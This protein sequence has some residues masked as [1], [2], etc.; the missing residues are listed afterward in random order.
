MKPWSSLISLDEIIA[1]HAKAM[2]DF[3]QPV[4]HAGAGVQN[5]VEGRLG[6]AWTSDSY[7]SDED[8]K[9]GLCFAGYLLFYLVK[10]HC[11]HDGNKRI[12]WISAMTVLAAL[13]LTVRATDDEA[14]DVVMRISDQ[15]RDDA[16]RDGLTVVRW[17]ALRLEAPND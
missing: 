11:F 2:A 15:T 7:A 10:D 5:C 3:G 13:G 14:E 6:N 16:I 17:L 1:L 9:P 8:A 12:G 4:A